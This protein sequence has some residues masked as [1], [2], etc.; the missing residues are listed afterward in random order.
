MKTVRYGFY[1]VLGERAEEAV[2][3]LESEID[4][5]CHIPGFYDDEF[6]DAYN[7]RYAEAEQ[8]FNVK[9]VI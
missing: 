3:W 7:A 5:L 4:F 9:F 1:R 6:A 8:K 2:E